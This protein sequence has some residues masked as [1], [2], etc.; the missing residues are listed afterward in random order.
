MLLKNNAHLIKLGCA[1]FY[2]ELE[3]IVAE[4]KEKQEKG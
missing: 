1:C 4:I 2:D 3:K